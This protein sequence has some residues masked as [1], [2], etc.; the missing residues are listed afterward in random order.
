VTEV[1]SSTGFVSIETRHLP[2]PVGTR[3]TDRFTA[4]ELR[5]GSLA[6]F[7]PRITRS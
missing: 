2:V 4:T 5:V 1:E 7:P 3:G 6:L